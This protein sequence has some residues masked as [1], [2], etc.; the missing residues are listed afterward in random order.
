MSIPQ[1]LPDGHDRRKITSRKVTDPVAVPIE[2]LQKMLPPNPF[3]RHQP[4]D[5]LSA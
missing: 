4:M 2:V 3:M 5:W 1:L